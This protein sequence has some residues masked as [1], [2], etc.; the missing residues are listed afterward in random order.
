MAAVRSGRVLPVRE[1]QV[2]MHLLRPQDLLLQTI[3]A[4]LRPE[5]EDL[6]QGESKPPPRRL[7]LLAAHHIWHR[8][9]QLDPQA[10]NDRRQHLL[11]VELSVT[12]RKE[13]RWGNKQKINEIQN[14]LMSLQNDQRV[15]RIGAASDSGDSTIKSKLLGW[16]KIL[17]DRIV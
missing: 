7:P 6:P 9:P 8:H 13:I 5:S 4:N 1:S 16:K 2:H 14:G 11:A 17:H 15:N 10:E 3:S 12:D